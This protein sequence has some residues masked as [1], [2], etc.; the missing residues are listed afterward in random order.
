MNKILSLILIWALTFTSA[1]AGGKLQNEDFKTAAELVTAGG[2]KAQLLNDTKVYVTGNGIN[3]TLSS[4]I[5]NGLIGG[6]GGSGGLLVNPDFELPAI[7]AS[8]VTTNG[9]SA[10]T[11]NLLVAGS[12]YSGKQALSI[13]PTNTS[14]VL[15]VI[16]TVNTNAGLVKTQGVVSV[17]MLIPT[18]QTNI[19]ICSGVDTVEITCVSGINDGIYRIYSIPFIYGSTSAFIKIKSN[20]NSVS[21]TPYYADFAGM[22]LGLAVQSLF[23]D[24]GYRAKISSAGVVSDEDHEFITGNCTVTGTSVYTCTLSGFTVAPNCQVTSTS[25]NSAPE[26]PIDATV[27]AT[28]VAWETRTSNGTLATGSTVISCKKTGVDYSNSSSAVY[29]QASKNIDWVPCTFANLTW[30]GLGGATPVTNNLQCK[31]ELGSVKMRGSFTVGTVAASLAQ[32]P[33]PNNWGSLLT[34]A[35]YNSNG[36][37]GTMFKAVSSANS[38]ISA[39]VQ[40]SVAYFETSGFIVGAANNPATAVNGNNLT[41]GD[42]V[43]INGEL[44]INIAGWSNLSDILGLFSGVPAVP[45]QSGN[46]DTFTV[47]FGTTNATTVCSASPCSFLDQIGT[48]V[49]SITRSGAGSYVLNTARTYIKIKCSWSVQTPDIITSRPV[50]SSNTNAAGFSSETPSTGLGAD[51]AGT[52]TCQGTY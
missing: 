45:G 52:L 42:V 6:S 8:W 44:S 41:L 30:Q 23:I 28:S 50:N 39:L 10:I 35:S 49:S 3:D 29:S 16:Q 38:F 22:N 18:V 9:T 2:T 34:S 1:F 5:T 25:G 13:T 32:I 20:G 21:T 11:T 47:S 46:V 33:L 26:S 14:S 24:P 7:G 48:A 37:A 12:V 4:A 31:K 27:T 19:Q 36:I 15:S 51:S 43:Q 40:P 17:A